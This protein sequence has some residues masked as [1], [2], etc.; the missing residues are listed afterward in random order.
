MC[1]NCKWRSAETCKE[2]NKEK[3]LRGLQKNE[4]NNNNTFN[5]TYTN[6]HDNRNNSYSK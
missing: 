4:K 5:F 3:V 2:C 1:K 6:N